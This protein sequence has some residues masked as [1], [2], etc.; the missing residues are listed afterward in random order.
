MTTLLVVWVATVAGLGI[1]VL[2]VPGIK[3]RNGP[4]FLLATVA[5][6]LINSFIRPLLWLLTAP[7]TVVTF[8]LFALVINA[9]MILLASALVP[10][11]EVKGFG[12]ALIGAVVMAVVGVVGFAAIALLSGADISWYSYEYHA[13]AIQ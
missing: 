1:A 2:I 3:A 11:F 10:G 13:H 9:L 7:L 5:L 6:G 8:G 4:A 12:S